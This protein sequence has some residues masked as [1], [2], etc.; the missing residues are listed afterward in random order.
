VTAADVSK[1][2]VKAAGESFKPLSGFRGAMTVDELIAAGTPFDAAVSMEVVEHLSDEHLEIFFR[3]LGR[4]LRPDGIAVITT[5]NEENMD[6]SMVYCP[7][8]DRIFHRWQH[9]R[10]WSGKTL[11]DAVAARG[12]R[13]ERVYTTD[14]SKRP[15]SDVLG[16]A[17]RLAKRALGRPE[18]RPHLVCI[19]RRGV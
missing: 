12:F 3:N 18:K 2:A 7:D 8:S 6:L 14:F 16:A 5:P 11:G 10:Q 1:D 13:V 17:K 4:L 15:S 19:A 9:V